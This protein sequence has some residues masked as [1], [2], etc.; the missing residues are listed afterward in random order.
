MMRMMTMCCP[1]CFTILFVLQFLGNY[2]ESHSVRSSWDRMQKT[3]RCCG[4]EE[5]ERGFEDWDRVM[6]GNVPD[7]CCHEVEEGC[8][9]GKITDANE[10]YGREDLDIW[11]DGCIEVLRQKMKVEVAPLLV[12]YVGVG[13]V[14]ALVQLITV[15]LTSAYAAKISRGSRRDKFAWQRRQAGGADVVRNQAEARPVLRTTET[16]F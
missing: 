9:R 10:H 3:L 4:G 8:G 12:A 6:R 5:Y 7:S 1:L 14:L 2:T 13:V 15:V 11:K 16:N